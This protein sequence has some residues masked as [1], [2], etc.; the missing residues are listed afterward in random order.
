MEPTIEQ[1]GQLAE[2]RKREV[3]P[4]IIPNLDWEARLLAL[5]NDPPTLSPHEQREMD[6][7][8]RMERHDTLTK[9]RGRL[10]QF[11]RNARI[12]TLR[13]RIAPAFIKMADTWTYSHGNAVMIGETGLGKTTTAAVMLLQLMRAGFHGSEADWAL[14]QD[15]RWYRAQ[16][17]ESAIKGHPL[18]RSEPPDMRSAM[19]TRLLV[20]DEL[21]WERDLKVI[22][23]LFAAR[24]SDERRVTIVTSGLDSNKIQER[25]GEAVWRRLFTFRGRS[26]AVA[27]AFPEADAAQAKEDAKKRTA[28]VA[29]PRPHT[30]VDR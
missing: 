19:T 22:D 18:G 6:R 10:P 21:G 30:E 15:A 5:S 16:E 23:D 11:V 1:L 25:Y 4:H 2:H 12:E 28:G 8:A 26:S 27:R 14:A 20:L 3:S 7:L 13:A 29:N 17:L 9:L 24:S